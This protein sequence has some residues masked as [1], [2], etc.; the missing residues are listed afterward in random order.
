MESL[1]VHFLHQHFE[2][3]KYI[4][5]G[6][7]TAYASYRKVVA[8]RRSDRLN[9]QQV[10]VVSKLAEKA[11]S[12]I[13]QHEEHTA[14]NPDEG[15]RKVLRSQEDLRKVVDGLVSTVNDLRQ[16]LDEK[17]NDSDKKSLTHGDTSYPHE[18]NRK[19]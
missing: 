15:T 13:K 4:A 8:D 7:S 18:K 17:K 3:L 12:H 19:G 1:I 14:D 6:I 9:K 11:M 5:V 2:L 16:Q 10:D